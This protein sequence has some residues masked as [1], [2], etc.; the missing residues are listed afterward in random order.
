MW[1]ASTLAFTS[2]GESAKAPSRSTLPA[3]SSASLAAIV[4]FVPFSVE[5]PP[6]SRWATFTRCAAAGFTDASCS[7]TR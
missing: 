7:V 4:L 1:R 2:S 6:A 3:L 5:R